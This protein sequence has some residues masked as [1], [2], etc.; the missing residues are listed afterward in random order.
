[1]GRA[2]KQYTQYI[3]RQEKHRSCRKCKAEKLTAIGVASPSLVKSDK[4]IMED[5]E[6]AGASDEAMEDKC[7]EKYLL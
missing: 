2:C 7:W 4:K 6:V 5:K 1:M 3:L